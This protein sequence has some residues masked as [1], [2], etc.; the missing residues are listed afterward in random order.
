MEY[1]KENVDLLTKKIESYGE[2]V[3][4]YENDLLKAVLVTKSSMFG[5]PFTFK[6]YLIQ[7]STENHAAN[8]ELQLTSE[9]LTSKDIF[10][11]ILPYTDIFNDK[12]V[13]GFT[14]WCITNKLEFVSSPTARKRKHGT[15]TRTRELYVL[16][17]EYFAN[18]AKNI[19]MSLPNHQ[20]SIK[21]LKEQGYEIVGYA[22]KSPADQRNRLANL[23]A[24]VNRLKERSFVDKCFVSRVCL[25][26]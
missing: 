25:V 5:S 12:T 9:N 11:S 19:V 26:I 15:N 2:L 3:L 24:M 20:N 6:R 21:E 10:T 17:K 16:K 4:C 22:R 18:L 1:T 7:S 23:T 14:Q 13:L 8:V